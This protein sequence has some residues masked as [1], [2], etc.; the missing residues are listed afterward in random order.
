MLSGS[1]YPTS[2]LFFNQARQIFLKLQQGTHDLDT[3]ICTMTKP[4]MAKFLK[5]WNESHMLFAFAIVL[6]PR[7]KM[8]AG[9]GRVLEFPLP[10]RE[11]RVEGEG[12]DRAQRIDLITS[13]AFLRLTRSGGG[14][15]GKL[16]SSSPLQASPLDRIKPFAQ[17][18]V[19]TLKKV[20]AGDPDCQNA[21]ALQVFIPSF[22]FLCSAFVMRTVH[23]DANFDFRA[24]E[25]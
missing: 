17:E 24:V 9:F 18:R 25:V 1:T 3:F 4:M 12:S 10:L 19:V 11:A 22:V 23:L 5:Y 15:S 13:G 8:D 14:G 2:N 6:D 21:F 16:G 7:F 20:T